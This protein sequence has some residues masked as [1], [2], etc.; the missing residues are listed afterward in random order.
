MSK[1]IGIDLEQQTCSSSIRRRR[2][3]IIPN[4]EGARTTP[5][6]VGFKNGE[7]QVGEVAKRAAITNPNTISSIKRHMGTNYKETIEGKDYSPQE[8][9]AIILQYLKATQKTIL[10]KL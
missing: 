3:K 9:S 2:S 8:I 1:I 5:S 6:V 10:V 7:R 4:P